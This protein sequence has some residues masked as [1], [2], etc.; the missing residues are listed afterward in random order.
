M[1]DALRDM[2]LLFLSKNLFLS[3]SLCHVFVSGP[4]SVVSGP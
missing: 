4:L 3:S 1:G 2:L